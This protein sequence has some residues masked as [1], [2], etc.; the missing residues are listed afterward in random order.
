M[1]GRLLPPQDG[2]FQCFP[3]SGWRDEF[4]I[5]AAAGLDAIEWIYDLHG[6]DANPI[7]NDRGVE[8]VLVLSRQHGIGVVSICADYFMDRPFVEAVGPS[9]DRLISD[10]LWL[11]SRGRRMG[12]ERIVLPFVDSSR[13]GTA[14][15][16]DRIAAML[17][18]VADECRHDPPE[19]H[20]ETDLDPS[21]FNRLLKLLP[22]SFIKANY[23]SGNSA[24]LAYDTQ[25]ELSAYGDRIGSVHIKDRMRA[26]S[27]VPLG[28]G[29]ADLPT[30]LTGLA[31]LSYRGDFVLQVARGEP[32][33]ELEWTRSNVAYLRRELERVSLTGRGTPN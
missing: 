26:G 15:Q 6:A 8:E 32:G 17:I 28:T 20:L 5:A 14:E 2:R 12:V 27:T 7:A 18:R 10:L 29:N 13:I 3:R 22:A 11:W 31:R 23:D 4:P 30:L 25:Q 16:F 21:G 9:F 1:Q 33:A 19:I 24:A